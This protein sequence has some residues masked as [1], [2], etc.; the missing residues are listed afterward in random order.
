MINGFLTLQELNQQKAFN[1][2]LKKEHAR[3][4]EKSKLSDEMNDLKEKFNEQI[5]D[6]L[7]TELA[8]K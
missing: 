7:K 6:S 2:E 8:K 4:Q 1:Q 5:I 3:L